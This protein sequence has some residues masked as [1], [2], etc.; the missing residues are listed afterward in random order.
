M[1]AHKAANGDRKCASPGV[2]N[3]HGRS[4]IPNNL[5]RQLATN[6]AQHGAS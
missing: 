3:G 4:L 1:Q 2:K 6:P 5:I